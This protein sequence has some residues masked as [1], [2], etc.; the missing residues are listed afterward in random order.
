MSISPRCRP[1]AGS[2]GSQGVVTEEAQPWGNVLRRGGGASSTSIAAV[3]A[4]S[5]W[6]SQDTSWLHARSTTRRALHTCTSHRSWSRGTFALFKDTEQGNS[7]WL[8]ADVVIW[9]LQ[10]TAFPQPWWD[11]KMVVEKQRGLEPVYFQ[12]LVLI[13][14][15][16]EMFWRLKGCHSLC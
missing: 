16:L 3:T 11:T 5:K 8:F 7:S 6:S 1:A 12:R 15:I 2:S 14:A 9:S 10:D 4:T 13:L